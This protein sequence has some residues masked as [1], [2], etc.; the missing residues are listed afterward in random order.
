VNHNRAR[1]ALSAAP[2]V[3]KEAAQMQVPLICAGVHGIKE[4]KDKN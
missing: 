2:F 1:Q 4:V 3:L